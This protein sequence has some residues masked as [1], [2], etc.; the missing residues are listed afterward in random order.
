MSGR[1]TTP[2]AD[3]LRKLGAAGLTIEQIASLMEVAE[4]ELFRRRL[5]RA[6]ENS[7]TG[8]L[9]ELGRIARKAVDNLSARIGDEK[10][11]RR[12]FL[13]AWPRRERRVFA[14][15]LVRPRGRPSR[16]TGIVARKNW[17]L[18]TLYKWKQTQDPTLSPWKFARWLY[19]YMHDGASVDAN[20]KKLRTLLK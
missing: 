12:V 16:N 11:A 6:S 4:Q 1:P 2:T 3:L 19:E 9:D 20:Y 13:D 8:S 14:A 5:A 17:G 10:R 15:L 7:S 18:V